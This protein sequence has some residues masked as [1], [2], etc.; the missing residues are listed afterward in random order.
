VQVSAA[1]ELKDKNGR[2]KS[3]VADLSLNKEALKAAIRF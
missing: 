3:M 2:P 1:R